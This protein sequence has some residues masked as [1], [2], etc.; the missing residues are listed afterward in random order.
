MSQVYDSIHDIHDHQLAHLNG[1]PT[2]VAIQRNFENITLRQCQ[3]FCSL[4][5]VCIKQN[6]TIKKMVGASKPI[7]STQFQIDLIDMQTK[8][9]KKS[10]TS[11]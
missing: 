11:L 3:M 6:P 7:D 8:P 2:H 10:T 4:C 9:G 5:P 1:N